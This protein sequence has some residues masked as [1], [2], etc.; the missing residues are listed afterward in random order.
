MLDV[1]EQSVESGNV[2][3]TKCIFFPT[4]LD[5]PSCCTLS[6]CSDLKERHVGNIFRVFTD[7]MGRNVP[8]HTRL[9][10]CLQKLAC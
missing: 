2:G 7:R 1:G 10:R 5:T 8:S 3:K 4:L 6:S 9:H